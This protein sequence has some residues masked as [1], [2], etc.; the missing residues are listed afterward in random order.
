MTWWKSFFGR[1]PARYSISSDGVVKDNTT[2]LEWVVGPDIRATY[3]GAEEWVKECRI[4]GGG[5]RM[6]TRAELRHLHVWDQ[7]TQNMDP[8]FKTTGR[9]IWAEPKEDDAHTKNCAWYFNFLHGAETFGAR[10]YLVDSSCRA[11]GVRSPI[12]AQPAQTNTPPRIDDIGMLVPDLSS[13]MAAQ[14]KGE[15]DAPLRFPREDYKRLFEAMASLPIQAVATLPPEMTK[16]DGVP[17][18]KAVPHMVFF[19]AQAMCQGHKLKIDRPTTT[20]LRAHAGMS[21]WVVRTGVNEFR[22]GTD[23]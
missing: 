19:F 18:T 22:L 14:W 7:K 6:P 4:A 13:F 21:F 10:N 3:D 1:K 15:K 8:V 20:M 12:T 2:G 5:W 9:C 23:D 11:F 16:K 17:A